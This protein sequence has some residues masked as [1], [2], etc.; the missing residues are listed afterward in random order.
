MPEAQSKKV[1]ISLPEDLLRFAD[2]KAAERKTSRSAMISEL[3]VELRA[4]EQDAL[5]REGYRFYADEA[6]AFADSSSQASAEAW[7]D[8]PSR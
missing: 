7:C 4:S 5:A 6:R 2:A 3:L 1:T 8:D